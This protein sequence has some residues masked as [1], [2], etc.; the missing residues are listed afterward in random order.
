MYFDLKEKRLEDVK[1]TLKKRFQGDVACQ[2][3]PELVSVCILSTRSNLHLIS[4]CK[5]LGL[6]VDTS[7]QRVGLV[8]LL[9]HILVCFGLFRIDEHFKTSPK[10]PGIDLNSTRVLFEKLMNSQHSVILEQV[11]CLHLQSACFKMHFCIFM[12]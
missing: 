9:L 8:F 1:V 5:L 6:P 4:V 7:Y 2:A 3:S 12:P 10:I 11:S